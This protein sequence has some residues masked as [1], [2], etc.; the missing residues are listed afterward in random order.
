MANEL[1]QEIR[2]GTLAGRRGFWEIVGSQKEA[3]ERIELNSERDSEK[4]QREK[5][6]GLKRAN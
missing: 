5:W 4:T 1:R 3:Q 2:G 6:A